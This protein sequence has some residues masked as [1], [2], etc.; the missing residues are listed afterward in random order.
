M[1]VCSS[2]PGPEPPGLTLHMLQCYLLTPS[3]SCW[4]EWLQPQSALA[5][6]A[7]LENWQQDRGDIFTPG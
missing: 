1:V 2:F 6:I 5:L 3:I 7:V 4:L